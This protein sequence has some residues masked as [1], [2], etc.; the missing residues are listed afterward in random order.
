MKKIIQL[1]NLAKIIG[2]KKMLTMGNVHNDIRK[3]MRNYMMT[4]CILALDEIGFIECLQK[5]KW[6]DFI[7]FA[8]ENK[9]DKEYLESVCEYLYVLNVFEKIGNKYGQSDCGRKIIGLSKGAFYFIHAYAPLF[10]N[11]S[12]LMKNEKKY[13]KDVFRR[14]KYVA[15]ATAE[16]AQWIPIPVVKNMIV[17]HRFKNVLDLG[18]GSARFLIK[19]CED[20]DLTCFGID[21]SEES[22]N[23]GKDLIE[24]NNMQKRISL[25]IG[26]IFNLELSDEIVRR[27]DVVTSMYVLHEFLH[28]DKGVVIKLLTNM[29]KNFQDKYLLVCELCRQPVESLRS[30]PTAIAEHHL[31]HAISKQGLITSDEWSEIFTKAGYACVE[32]Q[33]F[34]FA[35]QTYFLLR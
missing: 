6:V 27:I 15:E 26:D 2:I 17:K 4:Q 9:I 20:N 35:G 18:C 29:K 19:L 25:M 24:K 5:H 7:R 22:I 3:Y 23:C 21:I 12:S 13:K 28:K 33:H 14:E 8:C 31:F 34:D 10:E 32:E 11:L 30:N 16:V 1:Y